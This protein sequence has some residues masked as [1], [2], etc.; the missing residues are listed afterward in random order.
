MFLIATPRNTVQNYGLATGQD[1]RPPGLPGSGSKNLSRGSSIAL[2]S[3]TIRMDL[4]KSFITYR[5][6]SSFVI[7]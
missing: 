1:D 7:S 5:G 2:N 3:L 4:R 6:C